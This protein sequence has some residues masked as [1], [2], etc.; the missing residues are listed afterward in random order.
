MMMYGGARIISRYMRQD[1]LH[2][3]KLYLNVFE[4]VIE[5]SFHR[6]KLDYFDFVQT[7]ANILK[8]YKGLGRLYV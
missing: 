7:R 2:R 1:L 8:K 6:K 4:F 5:E 3:V